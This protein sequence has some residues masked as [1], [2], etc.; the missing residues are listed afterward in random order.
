MMNPEN[1]NQLEAK[2][3]ALLLGEL[4]ASEA[5]E[6]GRAIEH[7]PELAKLYQRLE[8]TIGLV[9][10]TSAAPAAADE[11][12]A[13]APLKLSDERRQS[14]LQQFKTV[15]PRTF[16]T[17]PPGRGKVRLLQVA[18]VFATLGIV[19]CVAVFSVNS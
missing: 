3:T 17:A 8:K 6:L 18:A 1:T 5:F 2:L 9:K 13:P 14:V 12:Q 10:E 15:R 19:V 11:S 4:P 7:D 16:V